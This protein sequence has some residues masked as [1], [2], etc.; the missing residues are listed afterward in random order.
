MSTRRTKSW[1]E[2]LNIA[3]D[4]KVQVLDIAFGGLDPGQKL[5]I[6][7]PKLVDAYIRAIPA[8]QT[9]SVVQMRQEMA[10]KAKAHGTCPL[11]SGIFTRIAAEA[12]WDEIEAGKPLNEVT[13][14][15]R[16]VEPGSALAKKLRC[17]EAWLKMQREAEQADAATAHR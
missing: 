12:A 7:T 3:K 17:G 14:F 2:K 15:W 11:T 10:R 6:A 9:R 8:G 16:I 5:Y 1:T 4:A 13:P